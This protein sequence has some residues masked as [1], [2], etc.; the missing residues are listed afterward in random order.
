VAGA[1]GGIGLDWYTRGGVSLFAAGDVLG[2]SD[3]STVIT[4]KAGLRVAF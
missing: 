4:G 1:Y 2:M 3:S